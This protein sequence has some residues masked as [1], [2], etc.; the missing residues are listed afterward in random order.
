MPQQSPRPQLPVQG[1]LTNT[2]GALGAPRTA[3]PGNVSGQRRLAVLVGGGGIRLEILVLLAQE[4]RDVGTLVR[5]LDLDQATVSH[6]LGKMRNVGLVNVSVLGPRRVYSARVALAAAPAASETTSSLAWMSVAL[7][8][9][10]GAVLLL[11]VPRQP[12]ATPAPLRNVIS[13]PQEVTPRHST[14]D[15]GT[16]Q[17]TAPTERAIQVRSVIEPKAAK[18][19]PK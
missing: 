6:H 19:K 17:P 13:S 8:A 7:E 1:H 9:P 4:A 11:G 18:S 14:A 5:N 16:V 3:A 2:N 10:K 15:S 12:A